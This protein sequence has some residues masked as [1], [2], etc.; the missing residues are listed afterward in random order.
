VIALGVT[1][2]GAIALARLPLPLVVVALTPIGVW[3]A[4]RAER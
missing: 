2:F 3:L 1:S 4:W